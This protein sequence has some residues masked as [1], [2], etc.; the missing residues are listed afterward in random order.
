MSERDNRTDGEIE[1]L[2]KIGK[3][4]EMDINI[5]NTVLHCNQD[6]INVSPM[7]QMRKHVQLM[8]VIKKCFMYITN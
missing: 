5:L 3:D 6:I 4:K 1:E 8:F 2:R 7:T